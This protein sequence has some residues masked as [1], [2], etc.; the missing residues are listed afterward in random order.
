MANPT[1]VAR[2]TRLLLLLLALGLAASCVKRRPDVPVLDAVLPPSPPTEG[3]SRIAV[4][5]QSINALDPDVYQ[6]CQYLA[7]YLLPATERA[8]RFIITA[9]G[10]SVWPMGPNGR[11]ACQQQEGRFLS[12]PVAAGDYHLVLLK[13]LRCPKPRGR[14]AL[15]KGTVY[16]AEVS[17][18]EGEVFTY[19]PKSDMR[20][21]SVRC[22]W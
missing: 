4:P 21:F 17:I 18:P 22:V 5:L 3:Q 10:N 14:D 15:F 12:P 1:L 8:E 7:G 13:G 9:R 6:G 11:L 16:L 2:T 19:T 20:S